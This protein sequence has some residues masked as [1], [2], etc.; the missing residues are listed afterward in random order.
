MYARTSIR[1]RTIYIPGLTVRRSISPIL[2]ALKANLG[3]HESGVLWNQV[4]TYL[5]PAI[6][7]QACADRL[8]ALI[9]VQDVCLQRLVIILRIRQTIFGAAYTAQVILI[10]VT[11]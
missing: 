4:G 1:C 6:L 8:Y 9:T 2:Y 7:T 5:T 11:F 3:N 10:D